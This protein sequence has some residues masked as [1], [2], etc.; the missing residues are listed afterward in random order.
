MASF[1]TCPDFQNVVG[2]VFSDTSDCFKLA[3]SLII[4]AGKQAAT[5]RFEFVIGIKNNTAQTQIAT[6]PCFIS[7]AT[8]HPIQGGMSLDF[9]KR[10]Q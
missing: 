7:G 3:T 8:F 2:R 6:G 9:S 10:F 5:R 1:S 4:P